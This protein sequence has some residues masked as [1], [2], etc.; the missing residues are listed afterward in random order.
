MISFPYH[1]RP[2]IPE[3]DAAEAA[4]LI[5]SSFRPWMESE[6]IQYLDNLH[7]AGT[8]ALAHPVLTKITGFPYNMPGVVCTDDAGTILGLINSYNFYL[9]NRKCS[10][11][12]NVCV[13][14]GYRKQGIGSHMLQETERLQRAEDVYGL[15]LQARMEGNSNY[16]FY[17]NNGFAVTDFR[18][19]WIRPSGEKNK[20]ATDEPYQLKIVPE[21]EAGAFQH[22]FKSRYPASILWNLDHPHQLFRPGRIAAV[23]NYLSSH[24]NM[25]R[26][27]IAA[28]G[29]TK[30]WAA[31]QQ[32][33]GSIDQLWLIPCQE[34]TEEELTVILKFLC[35]QYKGRKSLKLDVPAGAE[36]SI[37]AN[38]GF[39]KQHTVA[40][41]WKRL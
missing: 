25:F 34:T 15:Y 9:N 35:H 33:P 22:A 10:L 5:K 7:K 6:N 14:D 31:F 2:I 23:L 8:D 40:W 21:A 11:I 12:A 13:R 3:Q 28:D 38:S 1:I 17:K 26:K 4:E 32:L 36:D 29:S 27:V 41:M 20:K 37:Y 16:H 30:A 18:E 19:T 39:K 24:V